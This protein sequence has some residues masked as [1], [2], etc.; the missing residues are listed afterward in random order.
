M[1]QQKDPCQKAAC[2]IQ[3]CLQVNSYNERKCESELQAMRACCSKYTAQQSPCCS[4]FQSQ[5]ETRT[6]CSMDS[7]V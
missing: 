6:A 1:S 4:G 2:A 3:K 5:R 7:T